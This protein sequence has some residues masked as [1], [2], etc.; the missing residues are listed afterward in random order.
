MLKKLAIV[1]FLLI[2]VGIVSKQ[3]YAYTNVEDLTIVGG[4]KMLDDFTKLEYNLYYEIVGHHQ[5]FGWHTYTVNKNI[6]VKYI[7]ETLFSYYNNGK[8]SINYQYKTTKKVVNNYDLK[9]SGGLKIKT[10]KK[11]KIF[12]DG[13]N[14]SISVDSHWKT[15]EE[16]NE[17]FDIKVS[18]EPKTQLTLYMYGEGKVTNGVAKNFV[19][20]FETARGGFEIFYVTTHYQRLEITPI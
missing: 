19:F 16:V 13:L 18:I 11:N 9:V 8:S 10:D 5:F 20:W 1:L 12:G 3:T 2:S 14:A 6:K 4:G 15:S 7:S 17:S